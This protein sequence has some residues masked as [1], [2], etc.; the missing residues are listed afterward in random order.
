MIIE[1]TVFF[2]SDGFR[3]HGNIAYNEDAIGPPA[4]LLC[5]PHPQLGGN[6]DNN[7]IR[8]IHRQLAQHG[9]FSFRFDYRGVGKSEGDGNLEV[10]SLKAFWEDYCSP[11]DIPRINDASAAFGRLKG[12]QG[13]DSRRT[14]LIGYSFGAYAA[15][16]IALAH[17]HLAA[18]ILVAPTIHFHDFSPLNGLTVPKLIIYSEND[19]SCPVEHYEKSYHDFAAPKEKRVFKEADHFFIGHEDVV[20]N[21]ILDYLKRDQNE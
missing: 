21:C 9:F 20:S 11:L 1:E 12:F 3:L 18:I 5:P 6:M 16:R 10:E 4:A 17:H 14:I 2:R 8:S 19:F 15:L 13:V 7:V